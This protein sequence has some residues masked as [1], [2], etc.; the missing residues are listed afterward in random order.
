MIDENGIVV[1]TLCIGGAKPD[2][3]AVGIPQERVR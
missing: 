1:E 2:H 3:A